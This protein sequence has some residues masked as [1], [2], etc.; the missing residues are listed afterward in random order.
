MLEGTITKAVGGFYYVVTNGQIR[1]AKLRGRLKRDEKIFV[2]DRVKLRILDGSKAVIE[3]LLPRCSLLFRPPVANIDSVVIVSSCFQPEP[4]PLH[5]D[6]MLILAEYSN[7]DIII[8]FNKSDLQLTKENQL[9]LEIYQQLGYPVVLTSAKDGTGIAELDRFLRGRITVFAGPS[10]VGKSSL[11]NA[12]QPGLE[13]KTGELSVK[14]GR[15]KHTTRHIELLVYKDG[16]VVD[17]PGF[18][19]ARIDEL[20]P[21]QLST[22]FIE[23]ER[24]GKCRFNDCRHAQEPNCAIKKGV[25]QGMIAKIRYNNYLTLFREAME[26][27]KIW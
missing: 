24:V 13:L 9:L 4:N 27:K 16:F 11:L 14:I 1:E 5:L 23:F 20:T 3:Q 21:E 17:T 8:C 25:E 15:G 19:N 7:L 6:R 22:F 10:G 12:L 2:G 18:S 26:A